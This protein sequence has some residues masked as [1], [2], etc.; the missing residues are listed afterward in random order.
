[1]TLRELSRK[2][3]DALLQV[4]VG[5]VLAA[6]LIGGGVLVIAGLMRGEEGRAVAGMA[7]TVTGICVG[8]WIHG[9]K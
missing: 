2:W 1:M 7:A 3:A 8:V 4:V 9:R 6:L 5:L